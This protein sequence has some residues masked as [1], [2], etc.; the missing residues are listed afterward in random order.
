M[1]QAAPNRIYSVALAAVAVLLSPDDRSPE[2]AFLRSHKDR[3][4]ANAS[5]AE[6]LRLCAS[7]PTEEDKPLLALAAELTLHPVEL[8]ATS[9]A[10]IVETDL[11]C[12]RA[13]AHMQ[14]PLAASRPT[15]GLLASAFSTLASNRSA[16]AAI[17][18]GPAIESGLLQLANEG[19]PVAERALSVP[20]PIALALN[21][22]DADHKTDPHTSPA[23]WP[24]ATLGTDPIRGVSLPPSVLA[25]ARR[26]ANSLSARTEPALVLRS[27]SIAE[28]KA[29]AAEIAR[30]LNL[31]PLFLD[32][33]PS[34]PSP[35]LTALVPWLLLQQLL[36]VFSL[37]LAPGERRSLPALAR[38][39]GPRLALCGHEGTVDSGGEAIPSW[40]IG[41]ASRQERTRLWEAAIGDRS[42]ARELATHRH[43]SGHIAQLARLAKRRSQLDGRSRPKKHDVLA[44]SWHS[45]GAD[46]ESLAQPLRDRIS[47]EAMVMT[48]ALRDELNRLLLRCRSREGLVDDLGA[49]A[50]ARY[51]PGVRALFTGPSGTGK[52]LAAGWLAT[53]LGLPLYRVDLAAVTSKYIGE[54]EKNLAQVLARAEDAEVILLFDEADSLF[55]KRTDV[56]EANDRFANGQTN[57]LLQRIESFDGIVFLTSNSRSRFD[58]AFFRRLDSII[59]FPVP[60]PAERRSLW[61]SH[62]GAHHQLSQRE[63]NQISSSGDLLGGNIRNAVLTAAVLARSEN[64]LISYTD[65]LQALTDE[66]R[67]LGKQLPSELH[68]I[69]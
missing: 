17:L 30:V 36:P 40:T 31:R 54:T 48:P 49:S 14:A 23:K 25:A 2:A 3:F 56:K 47:D 9:L 45:E 22:A 43:S 35:A 29:A 34:K 60:G 7:S 64:R 19:S 62:L 10:S 33:E 67:K 18:T 51:R 6:S 21:E 50:S 12:G 52:T 68:R 41:I 63:L 20:L 11:M 37:Q 8:L 39:S 5:L 42:L 53:R 13:I 59:E 1:T 16:I 32:L 61:H 24:G 4:P 28:A 44:V 38:Y 46:L 26:H 66:Y 58:A 27:G 65:V 69:A 55:G 57:Y 15:L